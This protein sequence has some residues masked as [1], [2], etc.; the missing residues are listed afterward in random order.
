M[1][2]SFDVG[3]RRWVCALAGD[4]DH[5]QCAVEFSVAASI[6]AVAD[7]LPRG[8]RDRCYAGEPC[9]RCFGGESSSVRTGEHD[10]RGGVRSYAWL[11]KQ[12]RFEFANDRFDLAF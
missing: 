7:C 10:V 11:V 5:V 3:D 9:K 8:S 1:D 4:E 2:A 12:L 6:K